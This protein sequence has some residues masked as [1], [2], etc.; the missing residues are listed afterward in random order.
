MQKVWAERGKKVQKVWV[1]RGKW[2]QAV[3]GKLVQ[4]GAMKRSGLVPKRGDERGK[5]VQGGCAEQEQK[6]W[7]EGDKCVSG[8]AEKYILV[9]E[10]VERH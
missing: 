1:E 4:R 6:G 2:V 3:Q 10:W 7:P 9:Q 8:E 5:W